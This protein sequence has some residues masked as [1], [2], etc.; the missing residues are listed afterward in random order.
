M[1]NVLLPQARG[2]IR[3]REQQHQQQSTSAAAAAAPNGCCYCTPNT[4]SSGL[5][6]A[7]NDDCCRHLLTALEDSCAR[8][9]KIFFSILFVP[10][11]QQQEQHG[12]HGQQQQLQPHHPPLP[13]PEPAPQQQPNPHPSSSH[14]SS[15]AF[16]AAEGRV[17]AAVV[18]SSSVA[19]AV[20]DIDM[21]AAAE[22]VH[23]RLTFEE[24]RKQKLV[25]MWH[26]HESA[27]SPETRE[28]EERQDLVEQLYREARD[29]IEAIR[30][31]SEA[32][33]DVGERRGR[34]RTWGMGLG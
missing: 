13:A 1:M 27:T 5:N 17:I 32:F 12:Q 14:Y 23:R 22:F 2:H 34:G 20:P 21:R 4:A 24:E 16:T 6:A 3:R 7:E 28:R 9:P 25:A 19:V 33:G 29:G 26:E 11:T 30:I 15:R 10:P 18:A 31:I 8:W